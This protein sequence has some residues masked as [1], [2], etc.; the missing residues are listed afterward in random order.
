MR[1]A[2]PLLIAALGLALAACSPAQAPADETVPPPAADAPAGATMPPDP[3]T[4]TPDAAPIARVVHYDCE[5]TP[6]DATFDGRGQASVAID[7]ANVVLRT[8]SDPAMQGAR[9]AD[10]QGNVLWTR[11]ANDA[12]LLRTDH[13][14]RVCTGTPGTP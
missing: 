11:G 6:V 14:D 2:P 12:I 5:G 9:Y 8:E 1:H 7:G 3:E 4:P 13:P 10:D